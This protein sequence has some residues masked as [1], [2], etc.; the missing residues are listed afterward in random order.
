MLFSDVTHR[1]LFAFAVGDCYTE[2]S[3]AQEESLGMVPKTA[4]SEFRHEGFRLIKPIVDRQVVF[5][6]PPNFLALPSARA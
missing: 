6:L 4:V 1:N 3:F 5:R 2:D